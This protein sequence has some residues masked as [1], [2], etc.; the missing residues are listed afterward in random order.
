MPTMSMATSV[1]EM[2]IF[3]ASTF[4]SSAL[5]AFSVVM[6]NSPYRCL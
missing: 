6:A 3:L 1:V 5:T 4:R 2:C